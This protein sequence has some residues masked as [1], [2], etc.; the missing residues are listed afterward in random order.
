M[1]LKE[2]AFKNVFLFRPCRHEKSVTATRGPHSTFHGLCRQPKKPTLGRYGSNGRRERQDQPRTA[3][4][5]ARN[6]L[7]ENLTG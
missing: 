1:N 3:N 6:Q 7:I 4:N 5:G 2:I